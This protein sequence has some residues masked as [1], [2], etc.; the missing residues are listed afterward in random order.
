MASPDMSL[1]L[2]VISQNSRISPLFFS[3]DLHSNAHVWER[4]D[5]TDDLEYSLIS[6]HKVCIKKQKCASI[7][8]RYNLQLPIGLWTFQAGN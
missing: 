5:E 4:R 8:V 3:N 2:P 7:R 1:Y 6:N